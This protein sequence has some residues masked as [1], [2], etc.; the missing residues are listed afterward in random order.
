MSIASIVSALQ[1]AHLTISGVK[2]AP[3]AYPSVLNTATMPIV[4]VWPEAAEWDM[5]ALGFYRRKRVYRVTCFLDPTAQGKAGAGDPYVTLSTMLDAF[6]VKYLTDPT[7]RGVVDTMT[8]LSDSGV[9]AGGEDLV[10]G[11]IPYW[12]FTFRL[13]IVEKT[14]S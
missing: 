11:A 1:T 6:G 3:T 2:T 13:S 9:T 4:L 12:G 8:A 10:W 14:S 5:A 7:L